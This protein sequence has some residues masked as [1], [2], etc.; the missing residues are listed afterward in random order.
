MAGLETRLG[1]YDLSS[2][3]IGASGTVGSLVD[4]QDV[5]DFSF[6]G[7]ATTKSVSPEP[8]PG[9]EPPRMAHG[10]TGMLN[11]IGIQNPGI[12]A[13]VLSHAD[14]FVSI[15]TDVWGSV[16]AHDID[17]FAEVA[18][19]MAEAGVD[20]IEVNLSCPNLDGRPFAFD[21]KLSADVVNAVGQA[22]QLP[23]GA[24]LSSDAQPI[25]AVAAAVQ[26][27][28]ADWVVV[29]NTVMGA[30]IDPESRRPAL[31]GL[32]GGYSGAPIRPIAIRSVLEI[33]MDLPELPIVGCGGVSDAAHVVEFLLAGAS[34]VAIGSAHFKTPRVAKSITRDLNRYLKRHGISSVTELIGAY[35]PW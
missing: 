23:I 34:A 21:P 10:D 31:S 3:L 1:S 9:R 5:I 14:T 27:A 6:Y 13:W 19:R 12:E 35:E 2:P 4:F 26:D 8:W 15:P 11:G 25:S 17:G 20:A 7:A 32:I 29:A 28:G 24:K 16:V 33:A 22:T 30:R 18:N